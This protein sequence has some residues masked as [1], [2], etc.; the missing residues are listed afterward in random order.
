LGIY[1]TVQTLHAYQKLNETGFLA[2]DKNHIFPD[3]CIPYRWMSEQ[4][5]NR[6]GLD[7][8]YPIWLWTAK[9]DLNQESLLPEGEKGVLLTIEISDEYVLLSDFQAWHCVL[10]DWFCSLTEEEDELFD[11]GK[12]SLSK[13]ESWER[14]FDLK[15][16][17]NSEMW[18]TEEQLIQGVT[19]SI[20]K[21]QIKEIELFIAK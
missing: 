20:N 3:F 17:R 2:G 19:P 9:P 18:I 21:S 8:S 12:I 16:I 13:E 1:Y 7:C 11:E 14:I 10:N 4:M 15:L 5:K 6:L